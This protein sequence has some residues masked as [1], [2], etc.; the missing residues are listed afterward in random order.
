MGH[1]RHLAAPSARRSRGVTV[2]HDLLEVSYV[3]PLRWHQPGPVEEL[4]AY[5]RQLAGHVELVVVDGSPEELFAEHHRVWH[6]FAT[7]IA[8]DPDLRFLYG[9]VNGVLTGVRHASHEAVV[10]ADDDVRYARAQLE[11]LVAGLETT[12]LVRP[13]NYFWPLPWHAR[14]DTARSLVNR[15]LGGDFP[16]TLAVRRS[17]V[18]AMGGYDGDV[19]FENLE[20]MRTVEA[21]GGTVADDRGCLVRRLPPTTGHF[22]GQRVRQAYD[23]LARPPRMA[24]NLALLPLASWLVARRRFSL[25]GAGVAATIAVA[26]VGRRRAGGPAVFPASCSLLAPVWVAERGV[27]AWLALGRRAQGGVP[28]AGVRLARAATPG[29]RL[30]RRFGVAAREGP[31]DPAGS[32]SGSLTTGAGAGGSSTAE[33]RL[34]RRRSR[35]IPWLGASTGVSVPTMSTSTKARAASWKRASVWLGDSCAAACTPRS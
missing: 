9:K 30:R 23:E 29:R 2:A 16:G 25:L 18:L 22:W 34:R 19:L 5:L 7:H 1:G 14:W 20:L 10:L 35:E 26:E 31:A 12:D 15:A 17:T 21:F 4:T 11:R 3:L 6:P 24:A 27:C 8:P 13:Q 33:P 28:Y 32:A